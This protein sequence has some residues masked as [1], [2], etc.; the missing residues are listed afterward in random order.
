[1]LE[2][3]SRLERGMVNIHEQMQVGFARISSEIRSLSGS[4]SPQISRP[5]QRHIEN[6]HDDNYNNQ[7]I[8][9]FIPECEE[10]LEYE[11]GELQAQTQKKFVKK[12][13]KEIKVC[14]F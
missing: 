6:I 5:Q 11:D 4:T 14:L 7:D 8:E 2:R 13:R 10:E 3:I 9:E 12:Q 1:M